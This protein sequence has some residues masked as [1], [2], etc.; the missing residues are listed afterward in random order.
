VTSSPGSIT[1]LL[2][3]RNKNWGP[4]LLVLCPPP[5][6]IGVSLQASANGMAM[7]KG[8]EAL[9]DRSTSVRIMCFLE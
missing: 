3:A 8:R 6:P 9:I 4:L 7:K 2:G 5:P 1:P